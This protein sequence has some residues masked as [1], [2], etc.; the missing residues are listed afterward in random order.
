VSARAAAVHDALRHALARLPDLLGPGHRVVVGYSGG[1]DSTCLLHALTRLELDVRAVHVDHGLRPESADQAPRIAEIAQGFG[2]PCQVRRVDVPAY[3]AITGWG[4]QQAARTA[5][6]QALAASV[7]E[8]QADVLLVAHTADDQAETLLLN[9]LRGTGVKGLGGMRL[10]DS[11]DVARLGPPALAGAQLA[12]PLSVARPLLRVERATT[13]AYCQDLRLPRVE[14]PSNLS[15][16]YT[17]N[18]VRM[19]L[20]PLLERFNPAI[21]GVL[22]RTADLAAEDDEALD[23][24][25]RMVLADLARRVD[26]DTLEVDLDR[27]AERPRGLRRRLLRLGLAELLGDMVDIPDAPIED[28]LDLLQSARGPRSYHLPGGVELAMA[29]PRFVLRLH[30]RAQAPKRAKSWGA[31]APGV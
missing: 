12:A 19:D 18:R 13:L 8:T 11:L 20:L 27:W 9:L 2:V 16:A 5:R 15:R 4:V 23:S 30:A 14:D 22:A 6:Y 29:S 31:E 10:L 7:A 17:R 3:Q 26:A 25:A 21:R 28:A 1:Q 24:L